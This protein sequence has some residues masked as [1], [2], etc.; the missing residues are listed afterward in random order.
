M[1]NSKVAKFT[2]WSMLIV[3][4]LAAVFGIYTYSKYVAFRQRVAEIKASGA[5]VSLS[6]LSHTVENKHDDIL[7]HVVGIQDSLNEVQQQM[8]STDFLAPHQLPTAEEMEKFERVVESHP[9]LFEVISRA[10]L[11]TEMSYENL[12]A[13]PEFGVM[14]WQKIMITLGQ[15]AKVQIAQG[16]TNEAAQTCLE[17][18]RIANTIE[19]PTLL[20][21]LLAQSFRVTACQ[22]IYEVVLAGNIESE[23]MEQI[24]LELDSINPTD[25]YRFVVEAE[26]AF[27]I[28]NLVNRDAFEPQNEKIAWGPSFFNRVVLAIPGGTASF[29]GVGLLDQYETVVE[30]AGE[31]LTKQFKPAS[32]PPGKLLAWAGSTLPETFENFRNSAGRSQAFARA[33]RIMIAIRSS[34]E[35]KENWSAEDLVQL[36]VPSE[37]TIDPFTGNPMTIKKRPNGWQVYSFGDN[38]KDNENMDEN[39]GYGPPSEVGTTD[40]SAAGKK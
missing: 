4:F 32:K 7:T 38:Q 3:A 1:P 12:Y 31:P 33:L 23:L 8:S 9:E 34:G 28:D 18:L 13:G 35:E 2:S 29:M 37:M 5:P 27:I 22:I 16:N 24:K 20:Q 25:A 39:V 19:R 30:R 14:D 26:R 36:G 10:A 21:Y 6:D 15:R 40:E 11:A 17:I